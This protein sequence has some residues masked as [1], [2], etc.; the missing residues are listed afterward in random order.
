MFSIA[1]NV[2]Y[3]LEFDEFIQSSLN[4]FLATSKTIGGDVSAITKIVEETFQTQRSF[5]VAASASKQPSDADLAKALEPLG[6]KIQEVR[7]I[8]FVHK[9]VLLI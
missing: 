5:L 6:K 4:P 1:C 7:I 2:P 3:V 8:T 9:C